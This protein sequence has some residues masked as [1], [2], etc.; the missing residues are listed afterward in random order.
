MHEHFVQSS[1]SFSAPKLFKS[2]S[3]VCSCFQCHVCV[4]VCVCVC[5]VVGLGLGFSVPRVVIRKCVIL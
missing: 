3:R 5:V 4:C 1:S 2:V